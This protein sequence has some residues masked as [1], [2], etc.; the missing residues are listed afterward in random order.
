MQSPSTGLSLIQC[1][2]LPF[3][4][5]DCGDAEVNQWFAKDVAPCTEQLL[6]KSFELKA[7]DTPAKSRHIG[8]VS[9]CNDAVLKRDLIDMLPVPEDKLFSSWPAVKITALAVA[10]DFQRRGLGSEIIRLIAQLFTT[11]NRTGCRFITLEAHTAVTRFYQLL[12]LS[13]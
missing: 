10:T 8:L 2:N 4:G 5:F 13:S 12:D 11:D 9:L 6:V 1:D 3:T 7:P